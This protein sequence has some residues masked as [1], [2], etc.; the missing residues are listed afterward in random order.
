MSPPGGQRTPGK[1]QVDSGLIFGWVATKEKMVDGLQDSIWTQPDSRW[2]PTGICG[3]CKVLL[4]CHITGHSKLLAQH[5]LAVTM[6]HTTIVDCPPPPWHTLT[7]SDDI[8]DTMS[9][10]QTDKQKPAQCCDV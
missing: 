4:Q 3:E 5:H 6:W 9:P 7:M 1:L 10:Q 8:N 2:S